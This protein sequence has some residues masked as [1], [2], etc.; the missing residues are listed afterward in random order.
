LIL[1]DRVFSDQIS[2]VLEPSLFEL[3]YLQIFCEKIFDYREKYGVHPS[4]EVVV[5]ILRTD[6]EDHNEVERRQ[7]REY[8]ARIL[9]GKFKIEDAEF[10]KE[11]SLEFCKKQKLKEAIIKSIRLLNHSSYD[12]IKSLID[13]AL[14]LGNDNNFGYDYLRDF[15]ERFVKTHRAPV[16]T[17]WASL[18]EMTEGGLGESEL[19]VVVAPTGAGKSMVLV[20]LGAEAL[21]QGKTVIHY[22]LELQD[23]V[24]ARRYD[25]CLSGIEINELFNHKEKILETVK[26]IE[27]KL[28]IKEYPT[29]SA[30][31]NTLKSHLD[32]LRMKGEDIGMIIVDYGDLLR[33]VRSRDEKRIELESIYEEL[34]GLAQIYE[35]P[36]WTA[37]QTNRS[38]LNAEIVTMEAISEAFNKCF[39]A[40]L[41]ISL[42]RTVQDKNSNSG[43]LFVA[44]NRNGYDGIVLPVFMNTS[45]VKIRVLE[46]DPNAALASEI[47]K[48]RKEMVDDL[49]ERYKKFR[50]KKET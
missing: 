30:S 9:S 38:G 34:R 10:I 8:F 24:V 35:C 17:G 12:R 1:Q 27:G 39:V 46:Y 11:T 41:I 40:D 36:V 33:P 13:D 50:N 44:K 31:T 14:R 5:T 15:E 48:S 28:I 20:H 25:S 42:S 3:Q 23:T 19:G 49:K 26:N 6:L 7:V 47:S 2:E 21:L 43:R 16:T 32:K 18:D 4:H 22:T 37:S 45:N 29:K